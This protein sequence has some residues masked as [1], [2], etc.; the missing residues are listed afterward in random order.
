VKELLERHQKA[1]EKVLYPRVKKE[2]PNGKDE[3]EDADDE[4]DEVRSALGEV[5]EH[6]AGTELFALAIAQLVA[7]TKHHLAVEE[8]ELLPDFVANSEAQERAE[9]GEKFLAAKL[10]AASA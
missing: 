4:H 7:T 10:A 2:V 9:L 1:E 3:V 5:A 8:A 6:E